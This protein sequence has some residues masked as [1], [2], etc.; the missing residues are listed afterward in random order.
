MSLFQLYTGV[1]GSLEAFYQRTLHVALAAILIFLVYNAHGKK[2]KLNLNL[3]DGLYIIL[4]IVAFGYLLIDHDY[5]VSERLYFVTPLTYYQY[6]LGVIAVFIVLEMTRRTTGPQLPVVALVFLTYVFMGPYMPGI[7]HHQGFD[8][9][10][11]LDVEYLT[12]SG[13]LGTAIAISSSYLFL[14]ILLGAVLNQTGFGQFL[15]DFSLAI[16]GKHRGGP[17]KVSILSSGLMGMISGSAVANV[18]TTGTFTIPLMRRV[19]YKP[20]FAGGIEAAS[21]AGGQIMPPIM[22][23]Q[24]FLM[25]QFTGIP[26]VDILKWALLPAI[27][28]YLGVM[29]M[30]DFEAVKL[31]LRGLE[32]DKLP[33]LRVVLKRSYLVLP[34]VVLLVI[35]LMGYTPN[36]AGTVTIFVAFAIGL[37]DWKQRMGWRG[38]IAALEGGAKG[39]LVVI[40]S[41]ATAGIIVGVVGLTGLGAKFTAMVVA[42][43]HGNLIIALLLTMVAGIVL[44]MGLPTSA[45]YI[46]QVALIV[47]ALIELGVPLYIAHMFVIYFAAISM[48]T[49]PVCLASFTAAGIAGSDPMKTGWAGMK[50]GAVAYIVPFMFVFSPELLLEGNLI[51]V[52]QAVIMACLG[53]YLLAASL[54]GVW[55]VKLNYG[56]R[57]ICFVGACCLI[58][59]GITTD[60]AGLSIAVLVFMYQKIQIK[61]GKAQ[62]L[63]AAL[64]V[65]IGA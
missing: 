58:F 20:E 55:K 7:F 54:D 38:I 63:V 65:E 4:S 28:Y 34:I 45:V 53:V 48:I 49:P 60:L 9:G 3:F 61:S 12:T 47:P 37:L 8:L 10:M 2:N 23:V 17:A 64:K 5:L 13:I 14:F 25:A 26:Y 18:A 46:I 42:W 6:I 24:A 33:R 16:A 29:L 21:S 50:I 30:A 36:F 56:I 43:S 57:A 41:C 59:P 11:L 15:M 62:D 1:F 32:K 19:G 31:G 44:G 27:L 52:V 51:D 39:A 35:L 22:G 40:S